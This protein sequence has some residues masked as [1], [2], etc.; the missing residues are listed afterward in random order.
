MKIRVSTE[1]DK[2]EML[3]IHRKAFGEQKG[4]EIAQ[5]VDDL[6]GDKTAM[7]RFSFVA[8]EEDVTVGH[9]LYTKVTIAGATE[10]LFAQILAPLAVLPE[11]Q[12]K[13]V[14][15]QLIKTSL[16]ELQKSD[17]KL[18]VVLGHPGYYPRA[19][20]TPAGELGFEAPYHIPDEY[21]GAWMVQELSSG[22][23]GIERGRV[24]CSDALNKPE[25]WRE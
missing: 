15:L 14:G 24:Q 17:V 11:F 7:P 12:R 3:S 25:H 13:G 16:G 22:I 5:L 1:T 9:I 19:G 6:L 23:I 4:P 2:S 20:F 21:S 10:G 18:V 8:V